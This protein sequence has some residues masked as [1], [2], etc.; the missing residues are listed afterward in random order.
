MIQFLL[1][2]ST[3]SRVPLAF[4][5]SFGPDV[6]WQLFSGKCDYESGSGSNS[7]LVG[8]SKQQA[9]SFRETP[10]RSGSEDDNAS[11]VGYDP[12]DGSRDLDLGFPIP[13]PQALIPVNSGRLGLLAIGL[14]PL[15]AALKAAVG[16]FSLGVLKAH[17]F[18]VAF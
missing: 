7:S 13:L 10:G 14:R 11:G 8:A 9:A 1:N 6:R 5:F 4:L 15:F 3:V 16:N 12:P 18:V 2:L 17:S